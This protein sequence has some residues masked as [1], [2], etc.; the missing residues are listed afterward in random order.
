VLRDLAIGL[1]AR[2]IAEGLLVAGEITEGRHI[3]WA[4]PA[5]EAILRIA[6]RWATHDDPFVM[7]GLIVWLDTTQRGQ[8]IG[9]S[10]WHRET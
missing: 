8:A 9:E 3:P 7:P 2:L 6:A 10:V 1:I 5:G 4:I